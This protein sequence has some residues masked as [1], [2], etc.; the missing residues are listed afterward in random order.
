[1][2]IFVKFIIISVLSFSLAFSAFGA[3]Y[4]KTNLIGGAAGYVDEMDGDD[5]SNG[6][7]AIVIN[8]TAYYH[9]VL[10]AD[11]GESENSPFVI[12]PDANAGDKR[13]ILVYSANDAYH[14][15]FVDSTESDQGVT[16]TGIGYTVYD[17]ITAA[18]TTKYITIVL[19]HKNT[20]TTTNYTF[21]SFETLPKNV[22]ILIENGA[23]LARTT[24]DE[25]VTIYSP[26]NIIAGKAQQITA[27][28]M[29]AFTKSGKAYPE[30]WGAVGDNSTDNTN[31]L[32]YAFDS[33]GII[34][35]SGGTYLSNALTVSEN[36]RRI[37][38]PGCLKLNN[39]Q[40]T[41]FITASGDNITFDG[42]EVDGTRESNTG[43]NGIH[44][45][46]DNNTVKNC[47]IHDVSSNA[48]V[49]RSGDNVKIF[50][51]TLYDNVDAQIIIN[52]TD[53]AMS[54][55]SV[56]N[57]IGYYSAT[58]I[59]NA[60]SLNFYAASNSIS[61]VNVTG[62]RFTHQVESI[63][64]GVITV[65]GN[66]YDFA[67]VGNIVKGADI[68]I[69]IPGGQR[70]TV[71]GNNIYQPESIGIELAT[72]A[73][74]FNTSD[75]NV[76][77]NTIHGVD[78][79]GTSNTKGIAITSS[80]VTSSVK[81]CSVS[82]NV[83]RDCYQAIQL[84]ETSS[85]DIEKISIYSNDIILSSNSG[86]GIYAQEIEYLT[87]ANNHINT[88]SKA[89]SYGIRLDN[90]DYFNVEGNF[91][92]SSVSGAYG[93]VLSGTSVAITFG[94]VKN[95]SYQGA[96]NAID[97]W[98]YI[99]YTG[100]SN[101]TDITT[102]EIRDNLGDIT[103][104]ADSDNGNPSA[105]VYGPVMYLDGTTD[106]T[107]FLHDYLGATLTICALDNVTIK[108]N[109][110]IRLTGGDYAMTASD[111]LVLVCFSSGVWTEVSRSVN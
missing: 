57:N 109:A 84:S 26:E 40:N 59:A 95:N 66:I 78:S 54:G 106:V 44:S 46:G 1:M 90:C 75:I 108:D 67:I 92:Y 22:S 70:G 87:I 8:E 48:I 83:I 107:D 88:N 14:K 32:Q 101:T 82:S 41:A 91:I 64:D 13:W 35:I 86:I 63:Y 18:S 38:G 2:K 65:Y 81:D 110:A 111:T 42:I 61:D 96:G 28:D 4:T 30:W 74:A 19:R 102:L 43:G 10:D 105:A 53:A 93:I 80:V 104:T 27:V 85:G 50:G 51:N 97:T 73:L 45:T 47:T 69:S 68:G 6:D 29:I 62:N 72:S 7:K 5:L 89:T 100:D 58:G 56:C 52:S 16:A 39:D 94:T 103:P 49:F 98:N 17:A 23:R 71:V 21:D 9:Y 76:T 31:A 11:S 34:H 37:E 36:N 77:G 55:I 15:Y 79:G 24:G 99:R 20:D 3:T 25:I 60:G 33:A 12:S